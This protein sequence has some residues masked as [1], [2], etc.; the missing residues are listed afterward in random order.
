[1]RLTHQQD[2]FARLDHVADDVDG[3]VDGAAHAA[4]EADDFAYAV[5][6]GRD[7]VQ[8][9]LD[10]GAV[11][12]R[13]AT[14]AALDVLQV[15]AG[16]DRVVEVEGFAGVARFGLATEVED[17]FDERLD[18]PLSVERLADVWRQD[19]QQEVEVVCGNV[20]FGVGDRSHCPLHRER[21]ITSAC[22]LA[23]CDECTTKAPRLSVNAPASLPAQPIRCE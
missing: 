6:Y 20:L 1:A 11:V 7:A 4:G 14:D 18:A 16:D 9:A 3:A 23:P 8:R 13:E 22:S 10:A 5:A 19:H 2:A 12:A 21:S 15:F 17:D